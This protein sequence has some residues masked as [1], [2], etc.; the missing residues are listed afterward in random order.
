MVF[1]KR[2]FI[3]CS[4]YLVF[5]VEALFW[6]LGWHMLYLVFGTAGPKRW[7]VTIPSFVRWLATIKK[8]SGAMVIGPKTIVK[9]LESLVGGVIETP[10]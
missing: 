2:Y 1:G 3:F 4:V 10:S 6:Y 9:P 5:V 8:P 7:I